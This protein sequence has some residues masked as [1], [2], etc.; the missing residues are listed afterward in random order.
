[1]QWC[2]LDGNGKVNNLELFTVHKYTYMSPT[3]TLYSSHDTGILV[4]CQHWI[5]AAPRLRLLKVCPSFQKLFMAHNPRELSGHCPVHGFH[6]RKIGREED[7]KVALLNLF[8]ASAIYIQE[9]RSI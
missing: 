4:P 2:L 7:I 3:R 6:H 8:R 1:M 9:N 5:F